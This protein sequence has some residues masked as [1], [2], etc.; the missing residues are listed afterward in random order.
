MPGLRA[1][2]RVSRW[3][4]ITRGSTSPHSSGTRN[5]SSGSIVV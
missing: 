3:R 5:R 1:G 4:T 2:S